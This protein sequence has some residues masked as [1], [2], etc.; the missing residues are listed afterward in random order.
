MHFISNN[1]QHEMR[2]GLLQI[3]SELLPLIKQETGRL[4]R[5]ELSTNLSTEP[6]ATADDE[7]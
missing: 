3:Q 7:D 5:A 1:I 2:F 4:K 6:L